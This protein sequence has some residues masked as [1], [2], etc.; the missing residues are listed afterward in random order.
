MTIHIRRPQTAD[1]PAL[2]DFFRTVLTDT[3][4]KEGLGDRHDDLENELQEKERYLA[5][6][7]ASLGRDR[8]F[9]AAF[10]NGNVVG[11]IEY[12]PASHLITSHADVSYRDIKEIGTVYVH[13]DFQGRGIGSQLVESI[14]AALIEIG[15]EVCCLDSGFKEAQKIWTRKFGEPDYLLHDYW[16]KGD[17]HMIW[18]IDMKNE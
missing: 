5:A 7:F 17:D 12:G 2:H 1:T 3:Y 14:S 10:L 9:L 15:E 6:D 16:G 11:T 18:K 4:Q 13:P 8:Y